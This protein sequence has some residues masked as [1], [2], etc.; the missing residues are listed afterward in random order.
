MIPRKLLLGHPDKFRPTISPNGTHLAYLAPLDGLLNIWVAPIQD[1][2]AARPVSRDVK[3]PIF[4][5]I[6]AYTSEHIL[7][8]QDVGGDEDWHVHCTSL[9]TRETID[10][11]PQPG[12]S[13]RIGRLSRKYPYE[14]LVAI[15]HRDPVFHDQFRVHIVSGKHELVFENKWFSSVAVDD[16][17]R[18]RFG[19]RVESDGGETIHEV[20]E[21]GDFTEIRRMPMEDYFSWYHYDF[22]RSGRKEYWVDSRGRDTNALVVTDLKKDETEVLAADDLADVSDLLAH[23]VQ[24]NIQAVA[25][26]YQRKDWKVL[27][28]EIAP[29]FDILREVSDGDVSILGRSDDDAHWIV[30]YLLDDGPIRFYRYDRAIRQASFLFVHRPDIEGLALAKMHPQ[31]IRARDG[32]NLVSYLT[33][34]QEK[35]GDGAQQPT[36]PVP[37][38]LLVHGGPWARDNWGLNGVH[39]FLANRGYAVLS[40][41][42][43]GSTGFGKDFI[44]AA[45]GEWGGRM[46]DDLVDAVSWAIA[47][48]IAIPD[49]VAIMGWS[50]G[51][52]ATLVGL[53]IT[54]DIFACGVCFVGISNLV[55]LLSSK[56][57]YWENWS[58][59]WKVR[60]GDHTTPDGREYLLSRSPIS[61]VDRI[62]KPLLIA[63]GANDVRCKKAESDQIV[64]AMRQ[65]NIPVTYLLY[66]DEGHGFARPENNIS[67]L[68]VAEA[69]LAQHLGGRFEPVEEAFS[70]SSIEI[71]YGGEILA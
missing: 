28:P 25:F 24:K 64:E 7:Y 36:Q 6:W 29:D 2:K 48:R 51:G 61:H 18:V 49:R 12:I 33:L 11:T 52:Y 70:G 45:N 55:T 4:H 15:N 50:Y 44:N 42:Y 65:R 58:S 22:D 5:Y 32:L 59:V 8:I 40:V 9:K 56:P 41:N 35:S 68:A 71:V 60:T 53:T 17:Y 39:Q 13:A 30:Q 19:Y 57:S 10:L 34:P 27:D 69:F 66:P 37:M 63:H 43:R 14:I 1:P 67:S 54:P 46:H 38:V 31:I 21:Q 23:P 16:D 20:H 26:T 3:R 62:K 47:Q